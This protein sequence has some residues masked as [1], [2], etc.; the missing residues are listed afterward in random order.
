MRTLTRLATL[1]CGLILAGSAAMAA[2]R[3]D[4]GMSANY[5]AN[6]KGKR[7]GFVPI[8]MGFDL[9]EGWYA[10]MKRQADALGYEIIVRDPNWST[11]AGVQAITS[12]INEKPDLLLIHNDDQ[13]S[14]NRVVRRALDANIPV[15]QINQKVA[16][17]SDAFV[18]ADWYQ[19]GIEQANIM[20]KG[21]GEGSGKSG[22][23]ALVQG[24]LT[25]P[26]SLIVLKGI[27]DVLAGQTAVKI[28][29]NQAADWDATKAHAVTATILKQHPDLCG[30]VG[31]WDGQ[32]VGTAAALREAN[33]TDQVLLTTSGGGQQASACDNV[34]NGNFD[35]YV[36]YDVAGQARDLNSAVKIL[37]QNRPETPGSHPWALYTPLK[38]FD[39]E[40]LV[41]DSCWTLDNLKKYGG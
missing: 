14:Y 20:I 25:S 4:D 28:V 29:A 19:I 37:L 38:V 15:V 7:V 21:C 11:E 30:I 32:D 17:N 2:D 5:Y 6:L 33:K 39:K 24:K 10:G 36:S 31:F 27:E 35:A 9:T 16:T 26:G 13:N 3:Y 8:G 23:I 18:G 12:L 1:A 22:E 40:G 34:A 41:A